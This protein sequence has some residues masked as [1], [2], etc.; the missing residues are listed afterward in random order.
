MIVKEKVNIHLIHPRARKYNNN[1][2]L[3]N[4]VIE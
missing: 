2:D 1:Y 4:S 3:Y